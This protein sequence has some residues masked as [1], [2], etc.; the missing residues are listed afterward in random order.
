M[1]SRE[2]KEFVRSLLDDLREV[3]E[4]K[5]KEKQ[6]AKTEEIIGNLQKLVKE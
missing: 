5:D 6:Y 3:N 1:S 4:E 2:F